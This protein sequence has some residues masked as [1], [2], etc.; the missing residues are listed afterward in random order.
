MD[1][2]VALETVARRVLTLSVNSHQ[3]P[4]LW[5]HGQRVNALA[6]ELRDK[7]DYGEESVVAE[8]LQL[9]SWFGTA[10]WA[11]QVEQGAVHP[12]EVLGRPT[13]AVQREL[14]AALLQEHAGD[15]QSDPI[16]KAAIEAIRECNDRSTV[17]PAAQIL[18]D[19]ENLAGIGVVEVLREFRQYQAEGRTVIQQV[20][21]WQRQIEYHYWDA[22][23]NDSFRGESARAMAR[24]RLAGVEEI[25]QALG[26][27]LLIQE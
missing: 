18:S 3:D 23:I 19:A 20:Q 26:R 5:E 8:T 11:V 12:H 27:E 15:R 7:P 22:R 21:K 4:W 17:L 24:A 1:P 9:A 25:M 6:Q 13:S 16:V 10:G 14:G 2:I